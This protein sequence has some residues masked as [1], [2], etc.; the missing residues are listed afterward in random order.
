MTINYLRTPIPADFRIDI[1]LEQVRA[2]SYGRQH[3]HLVDG[4][5]KRLVHFVSKPKEYAELAIAWSTTPHTDA[6]QDDSCVGCEGCHS[7]FPPFENYLPRAMFVDGWYAQTLVVRDIMSGPVRGA[8][9]VRYRSRTL[10]CG[11]EVMFDISLQLHSLFVVEDYW[12]CRYGNTLLATTVELLLVL[13][14]EVER[15]ADIDPGQTSLHIRLDMTP[16]T[17][18]PGGALKFRGE[19]LA[20]RYLEFVE[21]LVRLKNMRTTFASI[22]LTDETRWRDG[23]RE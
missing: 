7:R 12:F 20:D 16:P 6:C 22:S 21:W 23:H 10:D 2:L 13:I 1:T 3:Q 15:L 8:L 14:D 17:K 9:G 19:E 18:D 5:E 4:F 11:D